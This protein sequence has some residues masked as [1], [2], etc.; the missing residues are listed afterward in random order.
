MGIEDVGLWHHPGTLER[1]ITFCALPA[2]C[3][4]LFITGVLGRFGMNQILAYMISMPLLIF[5][6]F[7]CVGW[8]VD[9]WSFKRPVN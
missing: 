3:I 4:G 6:R 5:G 8:L 1:I 7:Y 2:F 9:R